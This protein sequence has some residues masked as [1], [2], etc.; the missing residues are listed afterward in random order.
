MSK[1]AK[2]ESVPAAMQ[3]RF[4]EITNPNDHF[5]QEYLNEDYA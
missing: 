5:C 4:K 3:P 2:S 1:A